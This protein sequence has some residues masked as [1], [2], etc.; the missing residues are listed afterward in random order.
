MLKY[1]LKNYILNR[2]Y[3]RLLRSARTIANLIKSKEVKRA[4]IAEALN[5]RIRVC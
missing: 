5:C 1:A 4:H 3:I 2:G